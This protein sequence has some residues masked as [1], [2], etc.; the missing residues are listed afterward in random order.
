MN[1]GF[2]SDKVIYFYTPEDAFGFMSNFAAYPI[3]LDGERWLTSEHYY[4]AQKFLDPD[5]KKVIRQASTPKQAFWL[6]RSKP[7]RSDWESIKIT[8]MYNALLA[9]F[10]QHSIL[11]EKLRQTGKKILVEKSTGDY[12]WGCGT[13][14]NGK[15]MLGILLMQIRDQI[16][17]DE[18]KES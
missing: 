14:G 1:D 5:L 10:T 13:T 3:F 6:G 4:Q 8:V 7:V 12:Y 17:Q 2:E 16:L 9:K 18:T 11:T 15:N